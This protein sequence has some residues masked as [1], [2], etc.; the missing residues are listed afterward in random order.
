MASSKELTPEALQIYDRQ[1][2]LGLE[3]QRRLLNSSILLT[4]VNG[5]MTE[6]AKNLVLCGCNLVLYDFSTVSQ[7]DIDCN[8]L[9]SAKDAGISK[10]QVIAKKLQEMNPLVAVS[11]ADSLKNLQNY[12]IIAVSTGNFQ[13]MLQWDRVSKEIN[14]PVYVLWNCG[15][16]GFFYASLGREFFFEKIEKNRENPLQFSVKSRELQ[17]YFELPA[18]K[19]QSDVFLAIKSKQN[20][21]KPRFIRKSD[22]F[23][24]KA[25]SRVRRG[26]GFSRERAAVLR[27]I[28]ENRGN[29]RKPQRFP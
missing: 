16:Y 14:K 18:K 4:P 15:F 8:F 12:D 25:R 11:Q 27:F 19:R 22:V 26:N 17:E 20:L 2:F 3:T 23:R 13:E 10:V 21:K 9:L 28:A 7:K 1:R 5:V 29:S 24:R 6:L